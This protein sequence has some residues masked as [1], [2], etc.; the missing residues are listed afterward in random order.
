LDRATGEVLSAEP[1]GHITSTHGVDLATGRLAIDQSK[2]PKLGEVVRDICP[3][4]PGMKDWQ[5]SSFSPRTGLVYMPHQ[6]LGMDEEGL[7]ANYIAGTPYVGMNVKMRAGPGGN[8][9]WVTAWDPVAAKAEWK[10]P[11]DLPVWSGTLATA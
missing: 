3:A 4:A 5:P 7:E 10:I 2:T 1:F 11:E 8:R 6:N 9:G